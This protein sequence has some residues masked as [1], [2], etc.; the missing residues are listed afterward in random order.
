MGKGAKGNPRQV[1]ALGRM[2]AEKMD[3]INGQPRTRSAFQVD[4]DEN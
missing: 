3:L 1:D 4:A 2:P